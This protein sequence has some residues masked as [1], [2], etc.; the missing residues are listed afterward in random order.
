YR[1][2]HMKLPPM[3]MFSKIAKSAWKKESQ[4]VKNEYIKLTK[5]AKTLYDEGKKFQESGSAVHVDHYEVTKVTKVTEVTEEAQ[6]GCSE[7]KD[8][9]LE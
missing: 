2:K 5:D 3:K 8:P 7:M 6:K 4:I 1:S 9:N